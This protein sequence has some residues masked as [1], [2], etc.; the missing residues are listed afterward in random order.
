MKI[1]TVFFN[2]FRALSWR[3]IA[4]LLGLFLRQPLFFILAIYASAKAYQ[5]AAKIYP[6]TASNN[7]KGNAFRHA[8]WNCLILMYCCKVSSPQKALKFTEDFTN[9]H[10]ELFPN[11]PLEKAMDL[12]NNQVGRAY[13][14]SLLPQIHRQFFET[15]FF[16]EGLKQKT[17]TA[18]AVSQTGDIPVEGLV[19]LV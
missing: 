10:E 16:I 6:K 4:K 8:Y 7:G 11:A 18:Q 1:I 2:A 13:F 5:K 19:Y 14:M 9:L 3:N 17:E 12:H 15:T